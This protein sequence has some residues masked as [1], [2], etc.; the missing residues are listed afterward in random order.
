VSYKKEKM[1][2]KSRIQML[3]SFAEQEPGNAFNWYGLALEYLEEEP[4]EALK[5]FEKLLLEFP[6]YLPSYYP[7]ANLFAQLGFLD[8][9]CTA[10]EAGIKIAQSQNESKT[11]N[12]LKNSYLNFKFENDLD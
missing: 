4:L 8:K 10:F 1:S 11:L 2:K 6:N 7:A 9:A 12:E 5:Y 3:Q